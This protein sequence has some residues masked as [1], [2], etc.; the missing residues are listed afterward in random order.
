MPPHE[1]TA[2]A[3]SKRDSSNRPLRFPWFSLHAKTWP[4][5]EQEVSGHRFPY[6]RVN[7]AQND[8]PACA[9]EYV[10]GTLF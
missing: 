4:R 2:P 3:V 9:E 7:S 8:D 10:P 5:G 1:D 6:T